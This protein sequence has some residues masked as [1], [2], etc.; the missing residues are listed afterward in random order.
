MKKSMNSI[1]QTEV[2]LRDSCFPEISYVPK[3]S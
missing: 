3:N 2:A 1:L